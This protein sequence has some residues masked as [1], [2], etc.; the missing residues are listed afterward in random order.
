[1][2]DQDLQPNYIVTHLAAVQRAIHEGADVRG[3]YWW[4]LVD[5]FEWGE[6]WDARFGLYQL[7]VESQARTK[8]PV[9][10]I[11]ARIIRENGIADDLIEKYGR[12]D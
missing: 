5:N 1:M 10:D 7:D 12:T 9:A 2:T 6:G 4:T 11:Y 8:R 3:Y